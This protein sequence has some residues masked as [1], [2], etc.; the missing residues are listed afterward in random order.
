VGVGVGVGIG[1]GVG[2]GVGVGIGVG[3]GVEVGVVTVASIW[4]DA[5]DDCLMM[6]ASR[7]RSTLRGWLTSDCN[8]TIADLC[9]Y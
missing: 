3:I 2:V 4:I 8:L 7:R 1:I 5:G 9:V 6:A